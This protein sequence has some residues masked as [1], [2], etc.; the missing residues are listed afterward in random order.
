[1]E[2]AQNPLVTVICACYNQEKF[3][4][5]SLNSVK[6]QTFQ[7]FELIIWDDA[8]KDNSVKVIEHW[9]SNNPQYNVKF[10]KH[11]TNKG[12]CA[13]LNE[14][15]LLSKGKYIQILALDDHIEPDKLERHVGILEKSSNQHALVFS[16]AYIMDDNSEL[17]QN[18]F[19]AYH[20][21]YLNIHTG[22]FFKQLLSLNFIPAMSVLLKRS[23]IDVVGLW[24]EQLIFE[25]YDMWLRISERFD[26]IFD[27]T[28]SVTY[29]MHANNTHKLMSK[30][31]RLSTFKMFLKFAEYPDVKIKL[32][33]ILEHNYVHKVLNGEDKL[34]FDK[35]KV[36]SF[37]DF[38]IAKKFPI[39]LFLVYR[40]LSSYLKK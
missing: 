13:S 30:E 36:Q 12:I 34:Y 22:N 5:D 14:C 23:V 7:N 38:L 28:P 35:F 1:M 19:I 11:D 33:N 2:S 25:D 37:Q 29:R 17:C 3:I 10:V 21:N 15:F 31:L 16:D 32:R 18:R 8:S 26:F 20:M 6:S 40:K 27:A 24:D 4:L 39:P 9:M